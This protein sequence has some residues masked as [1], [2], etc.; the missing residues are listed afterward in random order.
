MRL[1]L[2]TANA[3]IGLGILLGNPANVHAAQFGDSAAE[4]VAVRFSNNYNEQ[5]KI[6]RKNAPVHSNALLAAHLMKAKD[7]GSPL[8]LLSP[9]A[10][11]RFVD[12]LKFNEGG[13]TSFYYADIES[14]LTSSQAYELLSLFGL[15]SML[16]Y[17]PKIR[18]SSDEDLD[19]MRA[20]G[21]GTIGL[22]LPD[23]HNDYWC[24]SRGTCSRNVGSICTSNC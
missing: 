9:T 6:M 15:Q 20:Y 4:D 22:P 2:L 5:Q 10:R 17:M 23:D 18:I 11:A 8:N 14:E 19:I 1:Q 7:S 3:V 24:T 21:G 13:V 16:Q 12:S